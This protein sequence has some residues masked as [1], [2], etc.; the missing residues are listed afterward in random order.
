MIFRPRIFISSTLSENLNIRS[1]I[2]AFFS[3]VGA[4]AMLYEKNLTPSSNTMT[5]RKDILDADFI[6]FIIKNQYGNRTEIGISGTHEELQ[7]ALEANIPKHVYIKLEDG[8]RDAQELIEEIDNNQISYYYFKDDESLLKRI[9]ETTFTIAK[10][11]MLKKVEDAQLPKNSVEKISF[12]YD[13][14]KAVE[15]MKIVESMK[16]VNNSLGVDWIDS[17]LFDSFIEPIKMYRDDEG[18]VFIDKK[19]E[20][21]LNEMLITYE[22]FSSHCCDYTSVPNSH[23]TIKVAILGE[24]NISNCSVC[25]SPKLCRDEYMKIIFEFFE[26]YNQLREYIRKMRVFVDTII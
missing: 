24:V 12:K 26:K 23:K 18:W 22:Q 8:E 5:Y 6:I 2:E 11:I 21:I 17:T 10:E 20:D 25:Y 4:E 1:E 7:L 9:K 13:Y 14:Y 3:S 19:I 15:I 16:R